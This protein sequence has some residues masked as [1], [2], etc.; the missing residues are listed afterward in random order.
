MFTKMASGVLVETKCPARFNDF[1]TTIRFLGQLVRTMTSEELQAVR[2]NGMVS[3]LVDILLQHSVPKVV[4]L[5]EFLIIFVGRTRVFSKKAAHLRGSEEVCTRAMFVLLQQSRLPVAPDM[6]FSYYQRWLEWAFGAGVGKAA[7]TP[8]M[9][10][11]HRC[12]RSDDGDDLVEFFVFYHLMSTN[13]TI[14]TWEPTCEILDLDAILGALQYAFNAMVHLAPGIVDRQDTSILTSAVEWSSSCIA[15][16]G[17]D[18]AKLC[19]KDWLQHSTTAQT[20]LRNFAK[21]HGPKMTCT[22]KTETLVRNKL[23]ELLLTG[24]VNKVLS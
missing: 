3:K 12:L 6:P 18:M 14:P 17:P 1:D 15:Q 4:D 13:N 23:E 20:L 16:I 9:R 5:R 8:V 7:Q 10:D 21:A 19:G 22:V 2:Q 11:L 24:D